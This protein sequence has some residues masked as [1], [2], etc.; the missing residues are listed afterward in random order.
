MTA[1][2]LN[3][4]LSKVAQAWDA[5]QG[6]MLAALLSFK[7]SHIA[8][9]K[10][11]LEEPEAAVE[12][13]LD[14]PLDEM[15]AAHLRACWA[16]AN[17]DFVEAYKCQAIVV[18]SF[19]KLL[20]SQKDDNWPLPVMYVVCLDL[21]RIAAKADK[22]KEEK[23]RGKPGET[24][25]KAS[26]GIMAC[27]RVCASDAR[28]SEEVTK[29]WGMLNLVNQLFKIYFKVNKLHLCKPLIRAVDQSALNDR[30]SKSQLVTYRYYVGR[31][32]MFD[33][34]FKEAEEY[35]SYAFQKCDVTV[36]SNKR[37]ILIYLIPVKMLLGHMPTKALL[38]K[39]DLMQF[40]GVVEAVKQGNLLKLNDALD[41]N[42]KFFI[43]CGIFL[44]LEKLK[45]ITYRNLFKKVSLIMKTHQIPLSAFLTALKFM[46]VE[47][48]DED[49]TACIIANLI[50]EGRIKGY[51]SHQHQKLVVSKQNSFPAIA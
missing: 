40:H 3:S 19:A 46:K 49:E 10:L 37:L 23:G 2:T 31:K 25:E 17:S 45:I 11:Q 6:E 43:R 27:F 7:D 28:A 29:R 34:N 24:L 30:F 22:Q 9:P 1:I 39:F 13:V 44:I 33:N 12:R 4:Y 32:Y 21:R 41:A 36:R 51:I 5:Y 18:N 42:E 8:N 20:A 50:Y 16:W 14:P 35:L 26:E 47:D 38:E 48:I 15:I